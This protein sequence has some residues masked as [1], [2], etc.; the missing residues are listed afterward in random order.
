MQ[1][2]VQVSAEVDFHV[3]IMKTENV[4]CSRWR[5]PQNLE[6]QQYSERFDNDEIDKPQ[7]GSVYSKA[8]GLKR[9]SQVTST[10]RCATDK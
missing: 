10:G 7:P 5:T 8:A 2:Y 6:W 9:R 1:K 4:S 3:Q